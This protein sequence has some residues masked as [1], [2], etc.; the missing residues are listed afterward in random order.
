MHYIGQKYRINGQI[1]IVLRILGRR[2]ATELDPTAL[3][4][5]AISNKWSNIGNI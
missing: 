2:N 1:F 3:Q 4:H 5:Y